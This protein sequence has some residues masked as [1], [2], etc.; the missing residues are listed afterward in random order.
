M[1]AG[2]PDLAAIAL[3]LKRAREATGCRYDALAKELAD[4]GINV[5]ASIEAPTLDG[6][7]ILHISFTKG[8]A[9]WGIYV[10]EAADVRSFRSGASTSAEIREAIV[11]AREPLVAA[12][13]SA[14]QRLTVE[15]ESF[16]QRLEA[17]RQ[18]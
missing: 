6:S 5:R 1:S 7:G 10:A 15:L 11:R 17:E 12:I 13:A 16:A 9:G 18:A 14:A 4:L 2:A 3:R 8:N